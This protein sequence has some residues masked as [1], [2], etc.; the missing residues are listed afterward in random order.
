M[1][2]DRKMMQDAVAVGLSRGCGIEPPVWVNGPKKPAEEPT[3][4]VR[5]EVVEE[6]LDE[7]KNAKQDR[8]MFFVLF[9][10]MLAACVWLS[11]LLG[12]W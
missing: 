5:M 8:N 12:V 6:L 4:C 9:V 7:L 1:N 11:W 10:I 3:M 2:T